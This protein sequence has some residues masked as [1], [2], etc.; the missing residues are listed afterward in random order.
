[1]CVKCKCISVSYRWSAFLCSLPCMATVDDINHRISEMGWAGHDEGSSWSGVRWEGLVEAFLKCCVQY[2]ADCCC[3]V[4]LVYW[5]QN[6]TSFLFFALWTISFSQTKCSVSAEYSGC[7]EYNVQSAL[8]EHVV[9]LHTVY[10]LL[11][12]K[13]NYI[14]MGLVF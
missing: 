14:G 7:A 13:R 1:M 10:I 11:S 3:L 2:S 12:L 6:C 5:C 9:Y 8:L 4:L